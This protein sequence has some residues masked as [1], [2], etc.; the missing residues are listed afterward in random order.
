MGWCIL[1]ATVSTGSAGRL[2]VLTYE[3]ENG[4]VTITD[5]DSDVSGA[6]EIPASI[7]NLPVT[8]IGSQAFYSCSELTSITIPDSVTSIEQQAFANC[9]RLSAL[10]VDSDNSLYSSESG[11]LF[12]KNKTTLI[13]F[14][15]GFDGEYVIPDNITSIGT[16]AFFACHRLTNVTISSSVT[17]IG[18]EAFANCSKLTSITI[19]DSVTNIGARAFKSCSR[20]TSVMIGKSVTS[21]GDSAFAWCSELTAINVD[22]S[23]SFFSSESGAL[24]DKIQAKLISFSPVFVGEYVIP[25]SVISIGISAFSSC[26]EL[27]SIT[28][29]D[30][31][32]TIGD[33]AFSSCTGLTN[34]TMGNSVISIGEKAFSWCSG[35]TSITIP[36]SV[37]TI[38]DSAFSTCGELTS[39]TFGNNVTSIGNSAFSACRELTSITIPD[40]VTSIGDSAFDSCLGLTSITIPNSVTSIGDSAFMGCD[41]LEAIHVDANNMLYSSENGVLFNK[42][43]AQLITFPAGI[44]GEYVIPNSVT[45]IG[46]SAFTGCDRLTS[47]TIPDSVTTIGD[48][49]IS[50][51]DRLT[52]ITI[53]DS[54]TNIGNSA[55]SHCRRL[56]AIH[57]DDNNSF[58]SSE[59]GVLFDKS[60]A[61]LITFPTGFAGEYVIPDSVT[62]IEE[63]A[64]YSSR[65]KSITIPD[66]VTSI[67]DSTFNNCESLTNVTIGNGVTFIGN[68]AFEDCEALAN[69]T[70]GNS[71][72]SIRER[73]FNDCS[74]LTS[75]TIPDSIT[76]IGDY[77]FYYC[78]GLTEAIFEGAA[79][80]EFGTRV[81]DSASEH[82]LIYFSESSTGFTEPTWMGYPCEPITTSG[83]T[84]DADADGIPD[85]WE[86]QV[87]E[88]SDGAFS[89]AS[90]VNPEDDF[91]GD[92]VSNYAEYVAGTSPVDHSSSLCAVYSVG[93]QVAWHG[94]TNRYYQVDYTMQLGT[95]WIPL[96]DVITGENQDIHCTV[97]NELSH[98]FFRIRCSMDLADF[99][100]SS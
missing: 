50:W 40:S 87:I 35:L 63:K 100:E 72:T 81:F 44:E 59:S 41:W 47:I 22:S 2:G 9:Y 68:S 67:G 90:Q 21:I 69:V 80:S 53:P 82:F 78:K 66:S 89:D 85:Q 15:S 24:V 3:I 70:I 55:L 45:A 30:S 61:K 19:P 36:D 58:Y 79:P 51:C 98:C 34:I 31:V 96:G 5:C 95:Q 33:S 20:L 86:Q 99:S 93:N 84:S 76:N 56:T 97:S 60:Q 77:A 73:A 83:N 46:N 28:I 32:I 11:V 52:S 10:Q 14:P 91:D 62:T 18:A 94:V 17:T 71:V 29:P 64:F 8:T 37:T 65:L 49:A 74:E 6:L 39:I 25:E 43:Q 23:N 7:E 12:N 54:V 92:G 16:N 57:V 26:R 27:T 13:T 48:S 88:A 42:D 38:G 4:E 75:I 1:L